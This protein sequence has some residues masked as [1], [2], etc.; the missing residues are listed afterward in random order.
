MPLY[1]IITQQ[2]TI[3]LSRRHNSIIIIISPAEEQIADG[4]SGGG[5]YLVAERVHGCLHFGSHHPILRLEVPLSSASSAYA[6]HDGL[7]RRHVPR[8]AADFLLAPP[9]S[10]GECRHFR[11]ARLQRCQRRDVVAL[12]DQRGAAFGDLN[13]EGLGTAAAGV[14]PPLASR[15][16][17]SARHVGLNP[18]PALVEYLCRQIYRLVAH[19]VR[20]R[21]CF[22][23]IRLCRRKSSMFADILLRW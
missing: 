22:P 23:S 19:I 20:I 2:V 9:S 15:C 21:W 11:R 13:L 10:I 16:A 6:L 12:V 14:N 18:R 3:I 4:G 17:V 8:T 7:G 5:G 1:F